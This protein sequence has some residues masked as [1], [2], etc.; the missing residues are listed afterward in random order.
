MTLKQAGRHA[1]SRVVGS[2]IE[3]VWSCGL[4]TLIRFVG[5]VYI[6]H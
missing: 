1:P 6:W 5:L 2:G 4:K 3:A